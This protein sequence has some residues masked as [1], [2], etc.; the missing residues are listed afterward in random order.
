[1]SGGTIKDVNGNAAVLTLP[2]PG[3]ANSLAD[4]KALVVDTTAP[5]MTITTAPV[6]NGTTTNDGTLAV[7][8][9][10]SE[11]T[12]NF[13]SGDVTVTNGSI[14][15]T[16]VASGNA[17]TT[18]TATFTPE[19]DGATTIKVNAGAFTDAVGNTSEVSNT[20]TWTYD[21]TSPTVDTFSMDDTALV[22]GDTSLVTLTFSEAVTGFSSND[23][24][25][26]AN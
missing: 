14:N 15:D 13:V 23:D 3:A 19:A 11:A 16:F 10:S 5:T 12:T 20:I 22:T 21:G 4:S 18:Y 17:G 26:A 2:A 24:I 9:T 6:V 25:T 1:M 8:F 7:T